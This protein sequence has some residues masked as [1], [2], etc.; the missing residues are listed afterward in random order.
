MAKRK[1]DWVLVWNDEFD[2]TAV[3]RVEVGLRHRQRLLRL[4]AHTWIDGLGQRG[5]AVL[6][7]RSGQRLRQGQPA[8]HPRGEGGAARLRLHLGAAEDTQA[9]RHIAV[10]QDLRPLRDPRQ[11]ALGQGPVA[12][13]VD[14]AADRC[15]WRLGCVGRNRPDGDRRREA[16]RGAEQHPLRLAGPAVARID[17]ACAPAARRQHGGRLACLCLRVGAGRNPLLSSTTCTPARATTGGAAAAPRTAK[18]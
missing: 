10:R 9:R 4:Q 17:H 18:A 16:A 7:T 5:A 13:A 15:L 2:G 3:D 12:S 1:D 11:G 8:D 6:H 14:A